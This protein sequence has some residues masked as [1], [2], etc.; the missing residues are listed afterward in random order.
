MD[1]SSKFSRDAF[2]A[3]G[4]L[5]GKIRAKRY[6]KRQLSAMAKRSWITL[7]LN[8]VRKARKR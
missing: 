2:V 6:T 7:R 8:A 1:A 5:G 3:C 4:A